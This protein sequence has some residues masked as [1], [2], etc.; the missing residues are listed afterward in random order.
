MKRKP[1]KRLLTKDK[2]LIKRLTNNG[3]SLRY[4]SKIMSLGITTIYY[5]VRKFK[6]R[7]R[8][9]F[10]VGLTDFEIGELIWAF[11]GDGSYGH[12][13]NDKKDIGKGGQHRIRYFLSLKDEKEY[14]NYLKKLLLKLNLNPHISTRKNNN[15]ITISVSSLSYLNFIKKYLK[16]EKDKTF[17]IR[18][19]NPL[20]SYSEEFLKGFARGLMDTDGFLNS[21]NVA[22]A[23][24]SKN[25]INN[26]SKIFIKFKLEIT[27]K[28]AVRGGN[29]RPLYYVR[30]RRESLQEYSKLIGFSNSHKSKQLNNIFRKG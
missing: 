9:D 22:C 6:P 28:V 24:I 25:L 17:S 5:Q 14:A 26:L 30:V 19:K 13:F 8:K 2:L 21:G 7:Q 4:I 23:C 20:N 1:N 15:T 27:R 11:A 3:K 29:R 16:W 12:Y 18:L 10:I